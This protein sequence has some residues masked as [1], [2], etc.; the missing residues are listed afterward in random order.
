MYVC[1]YE[2]IVKRELSLNNELAAAVTAIIECMAKWSG[3][4]IYC[5]QND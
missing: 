2:Y 5:W 1:M 4:G 3:G